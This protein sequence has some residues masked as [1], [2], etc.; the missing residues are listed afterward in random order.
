L[1]YIANVSVH[2]TAVRRVYIF[3]EEYAGINNMARLKRSRLALIGIAAAKQIVCRDSRKELNAT[4]ILA[5]H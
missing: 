4:G 5:P 3:K 2:H 1:F